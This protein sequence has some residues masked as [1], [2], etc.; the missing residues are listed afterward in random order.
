MAKNNPGGFTFFELIIVMVIV[1]FMT[2]LAIPRF[3]NSMTHVELKSTVRQTIAILHQARDMAYFQKK[4]IKIAFDLEKNSIAVSQYTD[5]KFVP[6]KKLDYSFSEGI[7][8]KQCKKKDEQVTKGIFD[9][10][11]LPNGNSSGGNIILS[12]RKNREYEVEVDFIT[13]NAHIIEQ[14]E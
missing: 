12:N 9:I 13:G 3:F 2:F 14:I 7:N 6:V 11:F 8:I 10:F 1:G 4:K 5:E